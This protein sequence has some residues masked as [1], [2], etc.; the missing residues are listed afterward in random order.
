MKMR[1][2]GKCLL[3]LVLALTL[4]G[5][6]GN[7][8]KISAEFNQ[9]ASLV[10]DLPANPLQW[11]V[12]SSSMDSAASTM[13]TLYGNDV[14]IGYARTSAQHDYPAGAVLALVTWTQTEDHR[15]FGAKIPAQVKSVEFVTV[16]EATQDERSYSYQKF[17]GTPLKLSSME[18]GT[19]PAE[20]AAH[21]L[22]QRAA[23]MP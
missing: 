13:S 15:W 6:A 9:G 5:C 12:I 19:V 3:G 14:A 11:R 8:P 7:E 16:A 23:V 10:G 22:S 17:E 2:K 1:V 18:Q 21:L 4:S 20:R